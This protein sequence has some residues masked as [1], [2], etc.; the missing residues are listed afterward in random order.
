[1]PMPIHL[2][3]AGLLL[4]NILSTVASPYKYIFYLQVNP[5]AYEIA[6]HG[7]EDAEDSI[8][9]EI[10]NEIQGV[11]EEQEDFF[12]EFYSFGIFK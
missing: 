12:M 9:Y 5:L 8:K 7:K 3:F 11:H 4:T 10:D 1:M 2:L 6:A